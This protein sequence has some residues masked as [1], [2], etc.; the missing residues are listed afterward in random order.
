MARVRSIHP[1]ATLDE[2]VATMSAFA[3]LAWAYLPCHA[4]RSGRLKDSCFSL[5]A[6]IFPADDIDVEA[7]VTE[8]AS[9]QHIIRYEVAGKKYIQIRNFEKYQNPH[10]NEKESEIPAP[11]SGAA[12]PEGGREGFVY[13]IQNKRTKHIKIG[14]CLNE[15]RW[16]VKELQTGS[17]DQLIL[18]GVTPG[19]S[20]ER[21]LHRRFADQRH[22]GEWFKPSPDLIAFIQLETIAKLPESDGELPAPDG[23]NPE[24]AGSAPAISIPDPGPIQSPGTDPVTPPLWTSHDWLRQFKLAWEKRTIPGGTPFYGD[25]GD[26]K[27]NLKLNDELERL[28]REERLGAQS[29]APAMLAAFFAEQGDEIKRRHYPFN[30]FV[31]SFGR[32]RMATTKTTA[33]APARPPENPVPYHMRRKTP[34]GPR[35]N[36]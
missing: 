8:L 29:R 5:K 2:D 32:L 14:K 21:E 24:K 9:R 28:P 36:P 16:R 10:K 27:A 11:G 13:F 12:A 3:R 4:D 17:V 31:Q 30:F 19:A 35:G 7:I 6:A 23:S 25:T 34:G 20:R 18:L 1:A 33:A 26:T 15:P 22:S